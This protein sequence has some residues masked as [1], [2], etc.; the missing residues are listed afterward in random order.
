LFWFSSYV[1]GHHLANAIQLGAKNQSY[2]TVYN[3]TLKSECEAQRAS[4]NLKKIVKI[5]LEVKNKA[6]VI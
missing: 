3:I 2:R 1:T 4:K 6:Q 5:E